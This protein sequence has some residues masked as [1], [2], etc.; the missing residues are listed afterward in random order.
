MA[1]QPKNMLKYIIKRIL[2]MIPML[3]LVLTLSWLLSY[4]MVQQNLVN[5]VAGR[6]GATLDPDIIEAEE[7]AYAWTVAPEINRINKRIA[8]NS[9]LN[10][11]LLYI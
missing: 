4:L 3:L 9:S 1:K 11:N 6:L 5:P 8:N 7:S 10:L 2:I